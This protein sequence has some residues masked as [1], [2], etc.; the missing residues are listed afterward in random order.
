MQQDEVRKIVSDQFSRSLAETGVQITALPANQ[1]QAIV[2]AMADSVFA[3][4]AAV[5]DEDQDE[6]ADEDEDE[7]DDDD[8]D[9]DDA[10]DEDEG[11]DAEDYV[12]V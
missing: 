10:E 3:A 11:D 2:S 5:E 9:D 4:I 8:D 6:D 7:D 1:L 12:F